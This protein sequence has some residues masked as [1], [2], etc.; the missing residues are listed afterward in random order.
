M[1][2]GP[3]E[4]QAQRSEASRTN[5]DLI[6]GLQ[7]DA[8]RRTRLRLQQYGMGFTPYQ[9]AAPASPG[10]GFFGSLLG[11]LFGKSS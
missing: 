10:N 9:P 3:D 11:G 2:L 5:T 4:S 6:D 7:S 8:A 1:S